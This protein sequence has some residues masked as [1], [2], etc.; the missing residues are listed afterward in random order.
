MSGQPNPTTQLPC[1]ALAE[2]ATPVRP[3]E[4]P[5]EELPR[6]CLM[7]KR[8]RLLSLVDQLLFFEQ[9][10]D[11][12]QQHAY[13]A[14]MGSL[15]FPALARLVSPTNLCFQVQPRLVGQV[16]RQGELVGRQRGRT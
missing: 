9:D 4:A 2:M 10:R 5:P 13:Q 14:C 6:L 7:L 8:G 15:S 11:R 12:E 16:R 3:Q 1:P